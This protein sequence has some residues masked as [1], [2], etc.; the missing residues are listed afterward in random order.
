MNKMPYIMA[1]MKNIAFCSVRKLI[2]IKRFKRKKYYGKKIISLNE[3]NDTI[4]KMIES[5]SPF[6]V[7]RLG[8]AELRTL[9]YFLENKMKLRKGFPGYIKKAMH[10]NAG[11]FPADD[12]HLMMFGETLYNSLKDVDMFGVW[13]NLM[14][15]YVIHKQAPSSVLTELESLEPYRSENPWSASLRGKKV[16]VVHPFSESILKQYSIHDKLFENKDVLPDFE[17]ITYKTVQTNA[18]GQSSFSNWFEAINYMFNEI[19]NIDFEVAIVGCGS[20]GLPLASMIK[21]LGKQVIHLA[22]AT[23]I[24]FGIRGS[25]WD[26]RKEMQ[27]YFNEYWIRPSENEKPKNADKVEGGCYW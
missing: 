24:L 3:T 21:G 15:D 18:G 16:L 13:Y 17:L 4:K 10:M 12:E 9:V 19:K 1:K 2:G 14:E 20:Y 5:G 25:R 23:Q 8:D 27:K 22:G 11:F 6:L 26:A 7:A